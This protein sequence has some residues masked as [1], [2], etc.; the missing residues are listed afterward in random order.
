[1]VAL[2]KNTGETVWQSESLFDQTAYVSPLLIKH[3]NK[4]IVVNITANYLFGADV[5]NGKILWKTKYT[6]IDPPLWHPEAPAINAN[7]PLFKD[8]YI[9]VTSGYNHVGAMFKLSSDASNITHVWT[10][11]TLDVH[12]GGVVLIDGYIYGAN[13]ENNRMGNWCCV[14]WKTG[15]LMYEKE[16]IC[17]GSIIS[18]E[19][20]LYC[21]EEKK[22][23][24]ALVKATPENFEIVSTFKIDKGS[25]PH[26]A[27]PVIHNGILYIRHGNVLMA[28]DIRG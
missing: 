3:S 5:E 28:F 27:H 22:G 8:G 18:A 1:M 10:D 6:D 25:G 20:M 17:K 14:D 2:D 15:N 26:W 4:N 12:I 13:W 11:T 21:Y 9:Y 7:T 23:N 19:K 16:W 24:V